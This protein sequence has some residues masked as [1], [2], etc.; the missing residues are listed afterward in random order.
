MGSSERVDPRL[1]PLEALREKL[2]K[3]TKA[4]VIESE[5]EQAVRARPATRAVARPLLRSSSA[6]TK[7][8]KKK[9]RTKE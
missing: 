2:R 1:A 8:K 4:E 3:T 7:T 9:K 5:V 6:A